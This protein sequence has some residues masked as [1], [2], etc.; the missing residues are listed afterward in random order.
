[1]PLQSRSPSSAVVSSSSSAP[2]YGNTIPMHH[3]VIMQIIRFIFFISIFSCEQRPVPHISRPLPAP[4]QLPTY[5]Q[6]QHHISKMKL[7]LL[8]AVD[9]ID[10]N[11]LADSFCQAVVKHIVPHWLGTAWAYSGVSQTPGKGAIA[12]GYFV[13]TVLRDAGLP[14]A[15]VKLAQLA[16]EQMINSLVQP[17][18]IQR[19]SNVPLNLFLKQIKAT[20]QGLYIIGLD[21]HTGFLYCHQNSI[22]FIHSSYVGKGGV[23]YEPAAGNI[24]L[25][26]SK[27]K[28]VGKISADDKQMMHWLN[29]K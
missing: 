26:S 19:F 28:V 14:V 2:V 22:A 27:Y 16:S 15:R 4:V 23:Q 11:L 13:T 10:K 7:D 6:A 29:H 18:F 3:P 21:N 25:N 9:K 8:L 24:I 5:A 1:M 20:G 17:E 12:C